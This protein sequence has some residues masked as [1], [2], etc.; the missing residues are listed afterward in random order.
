LRVRV[1]IPELLPELCEFLESRGYEVVGNGGDEVNVVW[2]QAPED[3]GAAVTLLA[4]LD[5]WRA[6]HPW[7]HARLDPQLTS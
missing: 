7:V 4:D 3:F 6:R 5:I 1:D 2:P